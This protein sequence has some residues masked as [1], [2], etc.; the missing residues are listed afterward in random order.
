MDKLDVDKSKALTNVLAAIGEA[1]VGIEKIKASADR[2][3][4]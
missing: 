4:L 3:T 2:S 1:G